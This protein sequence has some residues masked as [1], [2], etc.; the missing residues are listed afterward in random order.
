MDAC[1]RTLFSLVLCFIAEVAAHPDKFEPDALV[2]GTFESFEKG[3]FGNIPLLSFS[4]F[5]PYAVAERSRAVKD[6]ILSKL[7][8]EVPWYK[9]LIP[10]FTASREKMA[11]VTLDLYE[12]FQVTK[13]TGGLWG[14]CVANSAN[15]P[16]AAEDNMLVGI[17][18]DKGRVYF[19]DFGKVMPLQ[20]TD[21]MRTAASIFNVEIPRLKFPAIGEPVMP[22]RNAYG[23]KS[24][25]KQ[26]RGIVTDRAGNF[27]VADMG[28]DRIVRLFYNT[29]AAKLE[30]KGEVKGLSAP[31]DLALVS[32]PGRANALV[33]VNPGDNSIVMLAADF[34]GATTLAQIPGERKKELRAF[35]HEGASFRIVSPQAVGSNAVHP[36]DFYVAHANNVI[37]KFRR[38]G[39]FAFDYSGTRYTWPTS[40][41]LTSIK[42]DKDGHVFVLDNSFGYLGKLT[43]DLAPVL[44]TGGHSNGD[45]LEP[46][47]L[48]FNHPRYL[49]LGADSKSVYVSEA[50]ERWSG[51]KRLYDW[52]RL[53]GRKASFAVDCADPGRLNLMF[54]LSKR[55][56]VHASIFEVPADPLS[57]HILRQEFKFVGNPGRNEM[58]LII[59]DL[60]F[61]FDPSATYK[62]KYDVYDEQYQPKPD[63]GYAGELSDIIYY[64]TDFAPASFIPNTTAIAYPYFNP[65]TSPASIEFN[66]NR[67]ADITFILARSTITTP[68]TGTDAIVVVPKANYKRLESGSMTLQLD[69]KPEDAGKFVELQDY[70][71]W[72]RIEQVPCG[73]PT[74]ALFPLA[75]QKYFRLDKTAPTGNFHPLAA[76]RFNPRS[77][78][79]GT[80]AYSLYGNDL[81][82]TVEPG[83]P[84]QVQVHV[85][86]S[87]DLSTPVR[88]NASPVASFPSGTSIGGSWDGRMESTEIAPSGSY[89]LSAFLTDQAGNIVRINSPAFSLDGDAP[90][91]NLSMGIAGQ[92][93][94]TYN[95][96]PTLL[97]LRD[98][99]ANIDFTYVDPNPKDLVV[100]F[101]KLNP[102]DAAPVSSYTHS[103]IPYTGTWPPNFRIHA[104]EFPGD[105]IYGFSVFGRD[106]L[107]NSSEYA[108]ETSVARAG[109]A[110]V[111]YV[112]VNQKPPMLAAKLSRNVIKSGEKV[113]LII[114]AFNQGSIPGYALSY[115]VDLAFG[116]TTRPNF[117]SGTLDPGILTAVI[118]FDHSDPAYLPTKGKFSFKV[119]LTATLGSTGNSQEQMVDLFVD[120]FPPQIEGVNGAEVL[121][122]FLISGQAGDPNPTNDRNRHGFDN[123]SVYWKAG[124]ITSL[125]ADLTGWQ[126]AHVKVPFHTLDR[127]GPH[128]ATFPVSHVADNQE[129][130]TSSL[131][132]AALAYLD[133]SS[134]GAGLTVGAYYTVLLV[135][136]E[137]G[138]P[139]VFSA[140]NAAL[141]IVKI[142]A[143]NAP[144]LENPT[145]NGSS[146]G[147]LSYDAALGTLKIGARVAGGAAG[148]TVDAT[149]YIYSTAP[150][151]DGDGIKEPIVARLERQ[152]IP[153]GSTFEML[154]DG[155]DGKGSY[156]KN[157]DYTVALVLEQKGT[158]IKPAFDVSVS[159]GRS[160][161]VSTPLEIF[162]GTF[163]PA[164]ISSAPASGSLPGNSATFRYKVSK[165]SRTFLEIQDG[166]GNRLFDVGPEENADGAG[167]VHFLGWEGIH[168]ETRIPLAAGQYRVRPYAV[169]PTAPNSKVYY[170]IPGT[171]LDHYLLEIAPATGE[172]PDFGSF[173]MAGTAFGNSDVTWTSRPKGDLWR[174]DPVTLPAPIRV[175]ATGVQTGYRNARGTFSGTYRRQH[176]RFNYQVR[177]KVTIARRRV[178]WI[179]VQGDTWYED[180]RSVNDSPL[181]RTHTWNETSA[182]PGS[183][184]NETPQIAFDSPLWFKDEAMTDP[185]TERWVDGVDCGPLDAGM[186]YKVTD[187][188]QHW[189][190]A[191]YSQSNELMDV[192]HTDGLHM[193]EGV[194]KPTGLFMDPTQ[195]FPGQTAHTVFLR[196]QYNL[197]PSAEVAEPAPTAFPTQTVAVGQPFSGSVTGMTIG[198]AALLLNVDGYNVEVQFTIPPRGSVVFTKPYAHTLSNSGNDPA[199]F[200]Y[201][202]QGNTQVSEGDK[203]GMP[204]QYEYRMDAGAAE[205]PVAGVPFP[206]PDPACPTVFFPTEAGNLIDINDPAQN[207]VMENNRPKGEPPNTGCD[208]QLDVP[209]PFPLQPGATLDINLTQNH[210]PA[211][212]SSADFVFPDNTDAQVIPVGSQFINAS[213]VASGTEKLLRLHYPVV[214]GRVAKVAWNPTGM[215]GSEDPIMEAQGFA[216]KGYMGLGDPAGIFN[217]DNYPVSLALPQP[218]FH[219]IGTDQNLLVNYRIYGQA[220]GLTIPTYAETRNEEWRKH[221]DAWKYLAWMDAAGNPGFHWGQGLDFSHWEDVEFSY[222]DKSASAD[223]LIRP[224]NRSAGIFTPVIRPLATPKRF[225]PI[226][227]NLSTGFGGATVTGLMAVDAE[228][229]SPV[230]EPISLKPGAGVLADGE[231]ILAYWP[232]TNKAGTYHIRLLAE[233]GAGTPFQ[234]TTTVRIGTPVD[235]GRTAPVTVL[236]PLKKVELEFP[237]DSKYAGMVALD[238]TV[239]ANLPGFTFGNVPKGPV[240]DVTPSGLLFDDSDPADRPVLRFFLTGDDIVESG[241]RLDQLGEIGIY[242][243]NDK[244]HTLEKAAFEATVFELDDPSQWT[245]IVSNPVL[246]AHQGLKL[247]GTLEHT[248]LYGAFSFSTFVTFDPVVSPTTSSTAD[249]GGEANPGLADPVFIYVS[250]KPVWDLS[251]TLVG[252]VSAVGGR[253]SMNAVP[254]PFEGANYIFACIGEAE[255][256]HR[257]PSNSIVILKDT[258]KPEILSVQAEPGVTNSA[259]QA[260]Q[261]EVILSEPGEVKLY[262]PQANG[263]SLMEKAD[264]PVNTARFSVPMAGPEGQPLAEGTYPYFVTAIDLVGNAALA[265]ETRSVVIDRTA[266][267]LRVDP[268]A[269]TGSLT[270][271]LSDNLGVDRVELSDPAGGLL[272]VVEVAPGVSSS[273]HIAVDPALLPSLSPQ[274]SVVGYDRGGNA[275]APV[276][277]ATAKL[278]PVEEST[279]EVFMRDD[280]PGGADIAKTLLYVSN[281]SQAPLQGFTLRLWI[282]R[283]EAPY[284]AVAIDRYSADPCGVRFQVRESPENG[285]SV[286]LDLQFPEDYVLQPGASTPIDGIRFGLHYRNPNGSAWSTAN[287]WSWSGVGSVYSKVRNAA[288]YD[289][290]GK[291]ISGLELDPLDV[292]FPPAGPQPTPKDRASF[293]P[294]ALYFFHEGSGSRTADVS[295]SGIPLDLAWKGPAGKAAWIPTG[296]ID[297]AVQDHDNILEN[298]TPNPKLFSSIQ[299]NELTLEAVFAPSNLTQAHSRLLSYAAKDGAL[300]RNW[301]MLQVG[302]NLEFRLRTSASST[303]SLVST[304]NPISQ[305]GAKYHVAMTYKPYSV[306]TAKGGMRIYVNGALVAS[307]QEASTL[308]GSG[309]NAW[310][311]DYVFAIGNRASAPDKDLHGKVYLA[312]VYASALGDADVAKN[313]EAGVKEPGPLAVLAAGVACADRLLPSDILDGGRPWKEDRSADGSVLALDGSEYATGLGGQ[314]AANGGAAFLI[315]DLAAEGLRHGLAGV[316]RK[317]TGFVG[318]KAAGGTTQAVLKIS[319]AARKPSDDEWLNNS[320]SVVPLFSS[321]G[322]TNLPLD[323]DLNGAKWLLVAVTSAV[324]DASS[325]GNF[326]EL[327]LRYGEAPGGTGSQEFFAGLEY[328]YFEGQWTALPEFALLSPIQKGVIANFSLAPRLKADDFAFEFTGFIQIPAGG[329]YTFFTSSDDGSA[330]F[331]DGV[332]VVDNDGIHPVQERSG[333]LYLTAGMHPIRVTYFEKTGGEQLLV[334]YQGPG[335]PKSK[336]PASV[337]F[338]PG[339]STQ[340]AQ[341]RISS[342]LQALYGFEDPTENVAHDI[343][344]AGIPLDLVPSSTGMRWI[345]GGGIEFLGTDH[346]SILA[347]KLPNRKLYDA[348]TRTS[349]VSLEAWIEPGDFG[350]ADYQRIL[351]FGQAAGNGERNFVLSQKGRDL[352]FILRTSGNANATLTTTSLP[353]GS[354]AARY[355]VV[356]T[357]KP[358]SDGTYG[359]MRIY[360]NSVQQAANTE[361]GTLAVNGNNAWK[362]DF[363]LAIG[364]KPGLMDKDWS[365]KIHLASV[366][367]RVLTPEQVRNNFNAGVPERFATESVPLGVTSL[368]RVLPSEVRS[369]AAPWLEDVTETGST[370]NMDGLLHGF[371][372][373]GMP[374]A[375]AAYSS[376]LYDLEGE[377]LALGLAGSPARL[378]GYAGRL[379]GQTGGVELTI[380]TSS[381]TAVPSLNDWLG[382]TGGVEERFHAVNGPNAPIDVDLRS[383]KWVWLGM[384]GLDQA[385]IGQ[386]AFGSLKAH[387]GLDSRLNLQPGILYDYHE[388]VRDNLPDFDA[389]IPR[390]SGLLDGFETGPAERAE[391]FA[392]E[393]KGFVQVL[394]QGTYT[395]FSNSDDGSRI[396]IDG[397]LVVNNDGLHG[398]QEVSGAV[399]LSTGYHAI[400]VQYFQKSGGKGLQVQYQGPGIAKQAI[401]GNLLFHPGNYSAGLNVQYHEGSWNALPDFAAMQPISADTRANFRISPRPQADGFGFAFDGY[402]FLP[403]SGDYTFFLN[404]DDGSRLYLDGKPVIEN[405]G[406]HPMTEKSAVV[407]MSDG[408]H[409]IRVHYFDKTGTEG[410]E[411]KLQGPGIAK[412]PIPSEMLFRGGAAVVPTSV[413]NPC[414]GSQCGKEGAIT[415]EGENADRNYTISGRQWFKINLAPYDVPWAS[416]ITVSLDDMDRKLMEGSFQFE[417]GGQRSIGGWYQAFKTPYPGRVSLYFFIDVPEDRLYKVRWWLE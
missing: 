52:P 323:L 128:A 283:E 271:T 398:M 30:Y 149:A 390:K 172:T 361:S 218:F 227:F 184:T 290:T 289:R 329:T 220:H 344:D 77:G 63:V 354:M 365:G 74:T 78:A 34:E 331:I 414:T 156:V 366:Y 260:I 400:K 216:V 81:S 134:T 5:S 380:K 125:P 281:A 205:I 54:E 90:D 112:W 191:V 415:M 346:N 114:S 332:K 85:Y 195:T 306:N 139:A 408:F 318:P 204:I 355:H 75:T 113:D 299:S 301:E 403:S 109:Q 238:P 12:Q 108:P 232:V 255:I 178:C 137:K 256:A 378:T 183:K 199:T 15:D 409:S 103:T 278:F 83:I 98:Q 151:M 249:I 188:R 155:K 144:R 322:A 369:G 386:G 297:F 259:T 72:A 97:L 295:G 61:A 387:F 245:D 210:T 399:T 368:T 242:Y 19:T 10:G 7:Q 209:V 118:G 410:L 202:F 99:A 273:W 117:A 89:V 69:I 107:E 347:Q 325:M 163:G 370:L 406:I 310:G 160:L 62:V 152:D 4:S 412:M 313:F 305:A 348:L 303:V 49:A 31:T 102:Q 312:S 385:D 235:A 261:V 45:K 373:T 56:V 158:G 6:D 96:K 254:L 284:A 302:K 384:A 48:G 288:I 29:A 189:W 382:T 296:G 314:A 240:V 147:D 41:L 22:K 25:F 132:N 411:V 339:A 237:T 317:L 21:A 304:G 357:Y 324:P 121:P 32:Q 381:A 230:W 402:V 11:G 164:R 179:F 124:Q 266:P 397:A 350:V 247:Q 13:H 229:N 364:N 294:L 207:W 320:G 224:D 287:D 116:A 342:G 270:G 293:E 328:R 311:S 119:R 215:V 105:G 100:R 268:V 252:S 82:A 236:S 405:D 371:G 133:G 43:H 217:P 122:R 36:E 173:T 182:A 262:F 335:I 341:N 263:I 174:L 258:R 67:E 233:N 17:D 33:V 276:L 337:L 153:M 87:G 94:A 120:N 46:N 286:A 234:V 367:N 309:T 395:F 28:N 190:T 130:I 51:L 352:Q 321:N 257:E 372:V 18:P 143:G 272:L 315:Y 308:V 115:T 248:S 285:N 201:T 146:T 391:N 53:I 413:T 142:A 129:A 228:S 37:L 244:T 193:P 23:D 239:P 47:S 167:V 136:K 243:L 91:I 166:A 162:D 404:S 123:Y 44:F 186:W 39:D 187:Y 127:N 159:T 20:L 92:N 340:P 363:I 181:Y 157:G 376:M 40:G 291:L 246:A 145:W 214:E 84:I 70:S 55:G 213:I 111:P 334:S 251:A 161:S 362:G 356:A 333:S 300:A 57:P 212:A 383:A 66:I 253:W 359:G 274:L 110:S 135:S 9:E 140:Q 401:P 343:S 68:P 93:F 275:S 375:N 379:D 351:E 73:I 170:I 345:P 27:W 86:R 26:P 154:W 8:A 374:R 221:P 327:R 353:L 50:F 171:S 38:T 219:P 185:L 197:V 393:Y 326:G 106:Q 80:L 389:L 58:P 148:T 141:R 60:E 138:L 231:N 180:Y 338:Y 165:A 358:N 203:L 394:T 198:D 250:D 292:E 416:S 196:N 407:S 177:S 282:S 1:R 126:S 42:S 279:V 24:A 192:L 79:F 14:V 336:I 264:S 95:G 88:M 241:G 267:V 392:F 319:E 211:R 65:S 388:I 330:L 71:L 225:L 265:T 169:V 360:V 349:Q 176:T 104:S 168:P 16:A 59:G 3:N 222:I 277:V 417:G 194:Q 150:D 76:T 35:W 377:R 226:L 131:G 223:W 206:F 280:Q 64:W 298:R 101:D 2:P 307:N 316:P 208:Y 200:S 396:H 175:K 269:V